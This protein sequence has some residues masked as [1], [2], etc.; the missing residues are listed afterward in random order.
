MN[1]IPAGEGTPDDPDLPRFSRKSRADQDRSNV[2]LLMLLELFGRSKSTDVGS[3]KAIIIY[4]FHD[5]WIEIC[6]SSF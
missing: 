3:S 2:S 5:I 1:E 6:G 4:D